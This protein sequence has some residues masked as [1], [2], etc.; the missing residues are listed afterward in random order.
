MRARR[1]LPA[2]LVLALLAV[3]CRGAAVPG[4]SGAPALGYTPGPGAVAAPVVRV[5]DGDTIVV[6]LDG[7]EQRV[8]YIGVNTPE[9]VDPRREVQFFGK[10]VVESN[11][12]LVID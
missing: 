1:G 4:A 3:A 6:R 2:A 7:R 9:S 12:L 11:S 10:V 8:R 5:V